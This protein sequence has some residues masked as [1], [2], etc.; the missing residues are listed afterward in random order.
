MKYVAMQSY[1]GIIL[2]VAQNDFRGHVHR[3]AHPSLCAGVHFMFGVAE[4]SYLEEWAF[5]SLPIQQ[6]ILQLQV[7]VGNPLKTVDIVNET[8]KET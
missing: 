7:S 3:C 4:V 6:Q 8:G 2:I 5:A 1:L